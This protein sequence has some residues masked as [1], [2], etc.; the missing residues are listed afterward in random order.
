MTH[1]HWHI[2]QLLKKLTIAMSYTK[3]RH[4]SR[5]EIS[6]RSIPEGDAVPLLHV[7]ISRFLQRFNS[8]P[9]KIPWDTCLFTLSREKQ[10]FAIAKQF[11]QTGMGFSRD[12]RQNDKCLDTTWQGSPIG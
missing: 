4:K 3:Q 2:D 5:G 8:A 7:V 9:V 1:S 6:W 12:K 10:A 11:F